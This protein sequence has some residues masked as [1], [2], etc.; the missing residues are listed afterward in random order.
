MAKHRIGV[1]AALLL[2]LS[3]VVLADVPS[4]PATPQ[5]L[6][7]IR[8]IIGAVDMTFDH[9]ANSDWQ[10]KS[11]SKHTDF[12][13]AKQ[14][15]RPINFA[16]QADRDFGIRPGSALFNA[17]VKPIADQLQHITDFGKAAELAKQIDGKTE[18]R[19]EAEANVFV[20]GAN[21]SDFAHDLGAKGAAFSFCDRG[22]QL[23]CFIVF[24]EPSRWKPR[25]EGGRAFAYAHPKGSPYVENLVIRFHAKSPTGMAADRVHELIRTTD[26]AP[27]SNALTR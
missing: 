7:A 9:F 21:D 20:A 11:A 15:D 23:D 5:E 13:V 6:A 25:S 2:A 22:E 26:W 27:I 4:R 3:T 10:Q 18:F 1:L 17:K 12:D 14:A 19:V 8:K 24:G 16:M